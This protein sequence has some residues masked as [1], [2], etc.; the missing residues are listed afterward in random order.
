ML[1]ILLVSFRYVQTVYAMAFHTSFFVHK[2][3]ATR[4]FCSHSAVVVDICFCISLGLSPFSRSN[5]LSVCLHLSISFPLSFALPSA[6]SI[7]T[8]FTDM[9]VIFPYSSRSPEAISL[10]MN[11]CFSG[12]TTSII[13]N[14]RKRITQ[15]KTQLIFVKIA[16]MTTATIGN[17]LFSMKCIKRTTRHGR[18]EQWLEKR[19][20]G[21]AR[22][23]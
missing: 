16:V 19:R 2:H 4:R 10:S 9:A 14:H 20:W 18:R 8:L 17:D 13:K 23:M 21:R 11:E 12:P 7:R 1:W 3:C 6:L 22:E 15:K 5:S